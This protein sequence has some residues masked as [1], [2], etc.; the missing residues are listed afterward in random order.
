MW[1]TKRDLGKVLDHYKCKEY[2]FGMHNTLLIDSDLDKV[3]DFPKN[4]IVIKDYEESD[5]I[6]PTEDQS[7]ILL[8]VR[9]YVYGLLE[10][11]NDVRT[12][13]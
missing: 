13:L 7:K 11:C 5:V 6:K 3:K 2:G 4:S 8:E 12:Y 9:D 1:A 10:E